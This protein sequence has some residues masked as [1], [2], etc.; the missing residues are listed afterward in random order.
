MALRIPLD[1]VPR[2]VRFRLAGSRASSFR[3]HSDWKQYDKND[4][5][6]MENKIGAAARIGTA[7]FLVLIEVA[8]V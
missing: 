7:V 1:W 4:R 2:K 5:K 8:G 6:N 3:W